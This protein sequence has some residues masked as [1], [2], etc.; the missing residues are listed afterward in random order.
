[1]HNIQELARLSFWRLLGRLLAKLHSMKLHS[2]FPLIHGESGRA[3]TRE[4]T[5]NRAR[6]AMLPAGAI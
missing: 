3:P 5:L 2:A 4:A 6:Y 1:M